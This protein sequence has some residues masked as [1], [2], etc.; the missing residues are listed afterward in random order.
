M[1]RERLRELV[2]TALYQEPPRRPT[3]PTRGSK[4]RRVEAKRHR[5]QVKDRRQ[6]RSDDGD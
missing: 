1:A 3:M 5:G 2:E 6:I 4:R